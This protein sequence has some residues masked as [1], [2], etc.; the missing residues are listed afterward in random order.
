VQAVPPAVDKTCCDCQHDEKGEP[1]A[2]SV[3]KSFRVAFPTCYGQP[4]KA[5]KAS[6]GHAGEGKSQSRSKPEGDQESEAK[7]ES[8]GETGHPHIHSG[9]PT[10]A[11]PSS[12]SGAVAQSKGKQNHAAES[13]KNKK[14]QREKDDRHPLMLARVRAGLALNR[15]HRSAVRG[16]D[17]A[18]AINFI[19]AKP[20]SWAPR[21]K[22][23]PRLWRFRR[24][25]G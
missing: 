16:R 25:S 14:Q 5:E 13:E 7:K 4:D 10:P 11:L 2:R 23:I 24:C 21:S 1:A 15:D 8:S 19:V 20:V 6:N 9:D 12:G 3:E 18:V 17:H 22:I